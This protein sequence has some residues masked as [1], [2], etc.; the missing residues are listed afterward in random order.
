MAIVLPCD[1]YDNSDIDED[2]ISENKMKRMINRAWKTVQED[3]T[4]EIQE[5]VL[6]YIDS[7][8]K[9]TIDGSN[10]TFYVMRSYPMFFGDKDGSQAIDIADIEVIEYT[11]DKVRQE[12]TVATINEN[13]QFTL[14]SAPAS[15][16][17]LTES[18]LSSPISIN[19]SLYKDAL[20]EK[21]IAIG[22]SKLDPDLYSTTSFRGMKLTRFPTS[23]I[24]SEK[25][26]RGIV[27][28]ILGIQGAVVRQDDDEQEYYMGVKGVY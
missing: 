20:I 17:K 15:G 4:L 25:K 19:H 7:Y 27:Q 26:Y 21:V 13:G 9:N 14:S 11:S 1:I 8:R 2:M 3:C 23:S 24:A 5:E 18:Y 22:Y 10:T 12:V 6:C 16:S 28:Q